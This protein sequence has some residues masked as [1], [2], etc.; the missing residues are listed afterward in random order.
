MGPHWEAVCFSIRWLCLPKPPFTSPH[1]W[2]QGSENGRTENTGLG[3]PHCTPV[4]E[5]G[6]SPH[7]F[8]L[9]EALHIVGASH[10]G[11]ASLGT[12]G[13]TQGEAAVIQEC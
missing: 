2:Q 5:V 3:I 1:G 10:L 7:L 8:P 12:H 13:D 4:E 11:S 9:P 6:V